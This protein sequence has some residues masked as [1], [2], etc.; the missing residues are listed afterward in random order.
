[1]S[2]SS[3]PLGE[4]PEEGITGQS[5]ESGRLIGFSD[6]IVAVAITI[7]ILP[8]TDIEIPDGGTD[9]NPIGII[10]VD[11]NAL[12]TSFLISWLVI[13]SFW[14]AHHRIFSNFR[15][16]NNVIIRW[17]ILWL[18]AI[19]VLP[20]SA[21]LLSQGDVLNAAN[22]QITMLYIGIL[23]AM[24]VSLGMIGRQA[25]VNPDL[26]KPLAQLPQGAN[27]R[28]WFLS[29]YMTFV[30]VA[31]AIA[32]KYAIYFLLGLFALDPLNRHLVARAAKR[33]I[34]PA[35]PATSGPDGRANTGE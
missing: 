25:A 11:H 27:L 26:L 9:T 18:F 19:V 33:A 10:W 32:P 5:F 22:R 6:G 3:S 35:P 31:A 20:F 15:A 12:I 34:P 7:L 21:N 24:S 8:L 14:L 2:S 17:N 1:M 29:I 4:V 13:M 23:L 28:G 30:F 16:V